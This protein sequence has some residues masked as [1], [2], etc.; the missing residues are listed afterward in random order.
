MRK[1]SDLKE[2]SDYEDRI[3][4]LYKQGEIR[5]PI[6]LSGGN[7]RQVIDI[8]ENIKE[9]DWV[10]SSY[11]CHYQALMKGISEEWLEKEI[12]AG[13]SMYIMDDKNKFYSSSIVPGQ[14]PIA[15]GVALAEKLKNSGN[16]VWAFCGDMAAETG[17]FHEVTKYAHGHNLPITFI[18]EDD[19]LSV[20]T[21]TKTVWG[22]ST[23]PSENGKLHSLV[24][25]NENS[26]LEDR[27][28]RYS[29]ERRYP[30]HGIGV[31]VEFP[32]EKKKNIAKG[33]EY[34]DKIKESMKMLANNDNVLF[35]GQTVN[36]KGSPI[37]NTLEGI[38]ESKRIELPIMEEVQMGISTG[39]SLGGF[40]PVSIY[41]RFDFL[42][43][44]ANQLVNHLDKI[45][46]LS[47]GRYNPKVIIRTMVGSKSPLYPG[48]QH[49]QD[50]TEAFK[51]MLTNIDVVKLEDKEKIVPSYKKA[52]SSDRSTLMIEPVD[53]L[54]T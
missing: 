30:H 48:P 9:N 46:E 33:E 52:L 32:E 35:L 1:I 12:I 10:F 41:P 19:G 26:H 5:A 38:S 21:P 4:K 23:F 44:A 28:I 39:L 49:V 8:F 16:H 51:K 25:S 45:Y 2:L 14:L 31:W 50:H 18:V 34:I 24:N 13:R 22:T 3:E 20:Y 47:D 40:I 29:Y 15:L 17:V 7:E 11:R 27:I 6:H 53:L 54:H 42:I 37:Y 36:Y 43:L